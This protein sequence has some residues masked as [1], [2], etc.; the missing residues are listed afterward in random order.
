MVA[1]NGLLAALAFA[2]EAKE[3]KRPQDEKPQHLVERVVDGRKVSLVRKHKGE[4]DI[5]SASAYHLAC[6]EI[7]ITKANN[8]DALVAELAKAADASQLRRATAEALAYL[9]Y[10]KRFVA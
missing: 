4:F 2:V 1:T 8:A 10:L 6:E 5:A 3:C 9:N 7:D